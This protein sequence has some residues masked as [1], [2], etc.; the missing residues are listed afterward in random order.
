M[1]VIE[2]LLAAVSLTGTVADVRVGTHWTAVVARTPLGLRAGLASTQSVH[3]LEHGRPGVRNAGDLL[4]M[5]AQS[6]AGWVQAESLT[7][8]S[9]GFAALNALLEVDLGTCV[10]RNAEELILEWGRGR[11]VAIVGHFPF[12]PKVRAAAEVCWVLELNPGPGDLPAATAPEVIPQADV[13]AITG[14]AL[15]NGTFEELAAACRPDAHVLVLGATTPL[16]PIMFDYGVEAISGTVVTDIPA[17]LAAVSQGANFRQITGKRLLTIT[18][19]NAG[20]RGVIA[21]GEK[22]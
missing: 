10:D 15:V 9:I 12:V 11:R 4:G 17:V 21:A 5:P 7:E 22:R 16:S 19:E 8:R 14:M 3:G 1:S 2:R 13:V 20:K 18:R 6:L